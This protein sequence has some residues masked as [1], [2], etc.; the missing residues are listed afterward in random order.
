MRKT[1]LVL[2]LAAMTTSRAK[3]EWVHVWGNDVLDAYV[4]PDSIRMSGK[5]VVTQNMFDFKKPTEFLGNDFRS[6]V[7]VYE[8]DC[9]KERLKV[10]ESVWYA[11]NKGEG[12]IVDSSSLTYK[13][14]RAIPATP[15]YALMQYA[16]ERKTQ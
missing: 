6:T 8:L 11:E 14:N 4:E 7:N 16:C 13:W 9:E 10:L 1:L 15:G 2:L 3:A 5:N 12:A